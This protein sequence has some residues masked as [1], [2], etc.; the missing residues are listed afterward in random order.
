MTHNKD[1]KKMIEEYLHFYI[2]KLI[3]AFLSRSEICQ[4]IYIYIYQLLNRALFK[5]DQITLLLSFDFVYKI[6]Y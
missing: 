1:G 5:Y 3:F 2:I 4:Y 6:K